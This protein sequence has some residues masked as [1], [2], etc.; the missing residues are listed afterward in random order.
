MVLGGGQPSLLACWLTPFDYWVIFQWASTPQFLHS[1]IAFLGCFLFLANFEWS[2]HRHSCTGPLMLKT[3]H[4]SW[5]AR[6]SSGDLVAGLFGMANSVRKLPT[7][8][9]SGSLP[10]HTSHSE[11]LRTGVKLKKEINYW[12]R[13]T[14]ASGCL[15]S[16]VSDCCVYHCPCFCM[17]L[18]SLLSFIF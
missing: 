10:L 18:C 5:V 11:L 3:I 7:P 15:V 6:T 8:L 9:Q 1:P 2:P 4:T 17:L 13:H 14:G 16:W 12:S